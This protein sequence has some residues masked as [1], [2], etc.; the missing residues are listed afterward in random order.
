MCFPY[1]PCSPYSPYCLEQKTIFKNIN[2][3]ANVH[4]YTSTN[5]LNLHKVLCVFVGYGEG[6]GQHASKQTRERNHSNSV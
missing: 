2:K 3:Q 4:I 5:K 6:Y 1:F